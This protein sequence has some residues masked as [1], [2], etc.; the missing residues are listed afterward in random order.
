LQHL[1][2]GVRL[3]LIIVHKTNDNLTLL[4]KAW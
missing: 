2:G 4:Q 1:Y 3:V